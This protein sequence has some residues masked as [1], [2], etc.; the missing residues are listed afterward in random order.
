VQAQ[1]EE[2]ALQFAAVSE[3]TVFLNDTP[4]RDALSLK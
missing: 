4:L 2:A 3:V 1:I